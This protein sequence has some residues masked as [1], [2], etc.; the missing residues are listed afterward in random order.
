MNAR[1]TVHARWRRGTAR[2]RRVGPGCRHR[3]FSANDLEQKNGKR[4][5]RGS[6]EAV[7]GRPAGDRLPQWHVRTAAVQ[8]RLNHPERGPGQRRPG[9][10]QCLCVRHRRCRACQ[11]PGLCAGGRP[12]G[13]V[14][15]L[16][17]LDRPWRHGQS[18]PGQPGQPGRGGTQYRADRIQQCPSRG[19]YGL[20]GV[21]ERQSH[22]AS[23]P[24]L[25]A[26]ELSVLPERQQC[27][28]RRRQRV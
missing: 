27:A 9:H 1:R 17:R 6:V 10:H 20:R 11:Q 14:R 28:D 12:S 13:H 26:A 19:L 25:G 2:R 5:Y 16:P 4:R 22:A 3:P 23:L 24:D 15:D 18:E 8:R 21:Q 7:D